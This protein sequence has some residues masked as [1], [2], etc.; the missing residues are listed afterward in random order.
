MSK[1]ENVVFLAFDNPDAPPAEFNLL[2][3]SDC[4]NKTFTARYESAEGFP[5]MYC[6]GCNRSIGRFGWANREEY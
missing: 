6:A 2:A 4:R 1:T 3:C 5:T